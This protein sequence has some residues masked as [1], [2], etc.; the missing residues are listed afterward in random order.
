[1]ICIII[2]PQAIGDD[3]SE[4]K[5]GKN[6]LHDL[7]AFN[8]QTFKH[9]PTNSHTLNKQI[10]Q[11]DTALTQEKDLK[12]EALAQ[13][14]RHQKDSAVEKAGLCDSHRRLKRPTWN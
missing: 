11:L 2:S 12:E 3:V 4:L 9:I 10:N 13:L 1:M 8:S 14:D 7:K 6:D 5:A